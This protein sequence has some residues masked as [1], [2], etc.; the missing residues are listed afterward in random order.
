D[1]FFSLVV[2]FAA[3]NALDESFLLFGVCLIEIG[4]E[5]SGYGKSLRV[6]RIFCFGRARLPRLIAPDAERP[7]IRRLRSAFR[8][9]KTLG[10]IPPAFGELCRTEGDVDSTGI[11]KDDVVVS[12]NVAIGWTSRAASCRIRFCRMRLQDPV[13]DVNDVDILLHDNV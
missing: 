3:D 12:V 6:G 2:E 5:F 7:D 4:F 1:A 10:H 13:A 8:T 9:K 11:L